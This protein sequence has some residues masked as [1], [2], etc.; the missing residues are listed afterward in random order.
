MA[1][2][3]AATERQVAFLETLIGREREAWARKAAER[4][5]YWQQYGGQPADEAARNARRTAFWAAVA[6]PADL[7]AREASWLIDVVKGGVLFQTAQQVAGKLRRGE[8]LTAQTEQSA[9][10]RLGA[11]LAALEA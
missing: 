2:Q 3:T 5:A 7:T 1:N 10:A 11:A 6:L 9:V 8:A 4:E